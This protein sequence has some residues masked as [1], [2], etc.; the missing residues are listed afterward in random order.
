[1]VSWAASTEGWQWREGGN[2]LPLFCPCEAPSAALC[3]A[4]GP[5]AQQGYRAVEMD[6]EEGHEDVQR[7]EH[8]SYDERLRELGLFILEKREL[9][10]DLTV[11]FQYLEGAY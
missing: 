2:C 1:M 9:W 4:L 3:P 10:G 7:A 8:L 6:P 5:P 11:I